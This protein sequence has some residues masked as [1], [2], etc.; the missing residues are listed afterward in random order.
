MTTSPKHPFPAKPESAPSR[1]GL[2]LGAGLAGGAALL[3][4]QTARADAPAA[5]A[6]DERFVRQPFYG[7]HQAGIVTP[8]PAS[9]IFVA[10][11]VIGTDRADLQRL[12]RTL[13]D[14]IAFL[15]QGGPLVSHDPLMPPSDSGILGAEVVPDNLT[16]T[17]SLGASLFDNRFGLAAQ[18]P[19][20][21]TLMDQF[22]NDALDPTLCHGDILLQ[23]CANSRETNI[24]ALRDIVRNTPDLLEIR[25][26]MDGFLPPRA[27]KPGA[28]TGRNLLGF[29]DGT[30]NINAQ[31][32]RVADEL[33][34]VGAHH[35]EPAWAVGGSYQVV[36]LIGMTVERWDRTPLR[37]QEKIFGRDKMSGAPLGMAHEHDIPDYTG[38]QKDSVPSTAHI[39]LANPRLPETRGSLI[40]RR[41]FNFSRDTITK[42]GQLEMG[43]LFCCYQSDLEK[44]FKTVQA[45]LNGEPLEEY[46]KPFGGGYFFAPPGARDGKDYIARALVEGRAA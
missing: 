15:T 6:A 38:A 46:I 22:P 27:V 7:P 1:R 4:G 30:A 9:A 35:A 28:E 8:Q 10:F 26:K 24:H 33:I 2:L 40:L 18:K 43:L 25:W 17:V 16:I 21:L 29:K 14:R 39:R 3:Q 13:T 5:V 45:R 19:K 37:E 32:T 42:A 31:D 23:F 36:R 41:G 11:N 20:Q 12:L 34:W 44:G